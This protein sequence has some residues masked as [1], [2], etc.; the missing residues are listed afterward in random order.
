[1]RSAVAEIRDQGTLDTDERQALAELIASLAR[2]L[3]EKDPD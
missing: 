2:L 1:V 3:G